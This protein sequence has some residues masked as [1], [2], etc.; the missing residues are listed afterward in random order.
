[1]AP[2]SLQETGDF[3]SRMTSGEL[4]TGQVSIIQQAAYPSSDK[5]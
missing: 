2:S 5:L 1:M 4:R 3:P